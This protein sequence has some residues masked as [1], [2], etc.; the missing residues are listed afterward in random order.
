[1][2]DNMTQPKLT[3]LQIAWKRFAELDAK[4]KS[5]LK[6]YKR[7]R[8][9]V[10][11]LAGF[12]VFLAV[13]MDYLGQSRYI[14]ADLALQALLVLAAI[15][16]ALFAWYANRIYQSGAWFVARTGA[17]EI[18]KQIYFYRTILKESPNR[19]EYL[20]RRLAIVNSQ[21]FRSLDGQMEIKEYRGDIPP[22]Y[23]TDD[24]NSP[25]G[26]DDL[27]LDEYVSRR[28]ERQLA[29]HI[30]KSNNLQRDRLILQIW[31]LVLSV[32]G[33]VLAVLG[34]DL[35]VFT[36]LA[37]ALVMAFSGW[38][39]L[40]NLEGA[41]TRA[42]R[43]VDELIAL[44]EYWQGLPSEKRN[45][46]EFHKIVNLV[47]G[48]L[49]ASSASFFSSVPEALENDEIEVVGLDETALPIAVEEQSEME[50]QQTKSSDE[51][52]PVQDVP[53]NEE[54]AV[55]PMEIVYREPITSLEDISAGELDVSSSQGDHDE[56]YEV[57]ELNQALSAIKERYQ[58]V[59]LTKETDKALLNKVLSE[60]PPTGDLKG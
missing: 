46:K 27:T 9:L 56:A 14:I 12:A 22:A 34:A 30:Q 50:T 11:L 2:E 57:Q 23:E 4:A 5:T 42:D 58:E 26:L 16:P 20:E 45:Q 47:E 41:V 37:L 21:I 33:A 29:E 52:E 31:I 3:M 43:I 7:L 35:G 17:V 51:L 25:A 40:R 18:L 8:R 28:L 44:Y 10:Y 54:Y 55:E 24:P 32:L 48:V 59:Q 6:S 60:Y 19:K 36:A 38:G 1:M 49:S 13:L 53:L 39:E 15:L